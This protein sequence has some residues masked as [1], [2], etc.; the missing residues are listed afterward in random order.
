MDEQKRAV[1][2]GY[3]QIAE[4]YDEVRADDAAHEGL[5]RLRETLP[6]DPMLL[7]LGCGAGAGPLQALDVERAVGLDFSGEQLRLAAERTDAALVTGDMTAL[8]VADESFDAVTALYSI[9]HLPVDQHGAC[10]AEVERVLEPGGR[11]LF[12]IGDNWAGA[13]DDWLESGTR[14]EWSYPELSETR[15]LLTEAGL[16][17]EDTFGVESEMDDA[18]WLFLLCRT[19]LE[20]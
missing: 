17:V 18:T 1:R 13:N 12:S 11:F 6:A 10:Y 2:D 9:I 8:P 3:N 16:T 5:A 4:R 7:D 20:N 15:R 19:D 14:M